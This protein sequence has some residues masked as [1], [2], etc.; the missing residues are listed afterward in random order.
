MTP[1]DCESR[2]ASCNR[3]RPGE[4]EDVVL[5]VSS[6]MEVSEKYLNAVLHGQL[7]GR[8][9]GQRLSTEYSEMHSSRSE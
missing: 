7:G 6:S 9:W 1:P 5:D 4:V 8:R 3:G 2:R